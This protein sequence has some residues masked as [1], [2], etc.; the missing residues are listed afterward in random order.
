MNENGS[1]LIVALVVLVTLAILGM[2]ALQSSTHEVRIAGSDRLSK[3]TFYAADGSM[4][5]G[6]ELL[7]QN[8]ESAAAWAGEELL[9]GGKIRVVDGDF[10]LN[11][12]IVATTPSPTNRDFYLPDGATAAQPHTNFKLGGHPE[13]AKGAAIQM[14]AGYEGKGKSAAQG[15][16]NLVYMINAQHR[17]VNN[18][19]AVVR[20]QWRHVN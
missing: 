20:I 19:E 18:S 11:E 16:S 8:I 4:E 2:I 17:G 7:E 14:V 12:D 9:R 6:S 5:L 3:E 1:T 13:S 10:W 15:G